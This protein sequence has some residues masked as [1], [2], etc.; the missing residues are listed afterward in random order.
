MRVENDITARTLEVGA[1]SGDCVQQ[2]RPARRGL[3]SK[4]HLMTDPAGPGQRIEAFH[5][6]GF[7][8]IHYGLARVSMPIP[9]KC[10]GDTFKVSTAHTGPCKSGPTAAGSNHFPTYFDG[11]RNRSSRSVSNASRTTRSRFCL[12][13]SAIHWG[14]N[15]TCLI[16]L[17]IPWPI[18]FNICISWMCRC[19]DESAANRPDSPRCFKR[20]QNQLVP[21]AGHGL[22]RL[23]LWA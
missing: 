3:S 23:C 19:T 22:V 16:R 17:A 11:L 9:G 10:S 2:S 15:Q 8:H 7:I 18:S 20:N 12:R 14:R 21:G 1:H 13:A 6:E 5:L 4:W